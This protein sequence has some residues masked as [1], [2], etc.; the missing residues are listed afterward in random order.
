MEGKENRKARFK[1]VITYYS[2]ENYVQFEGITEGEI[3]NE[4]K[5]TEGF[6][7][8]PIFVPQGSTKAYAEM[9]LKRRTNSAIAKKVS[10]CLP[11]IYNKLASDI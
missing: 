1:T 11:T 7:Y 8:D 6:G 5:G 2:R 10:T 9:T 3:L 4:R